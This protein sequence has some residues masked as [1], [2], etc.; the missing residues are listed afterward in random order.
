MNIK[1]PIL[2]IYFIYPRLLFMD[3]NTWKEGSTQW[4]L[5]YFHLDKIQYLS[6]EKV[7]SEMLF[8]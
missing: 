8:F 4:N 7:C 1:S 5:R 3:A 2:F 6:E